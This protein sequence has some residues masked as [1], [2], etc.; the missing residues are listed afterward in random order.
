MPKFDSANPGLRFSPGRSGNPVGRPKSVDK[1]R[2]EVASELVQ[3]GKTLTQMAV[4]RALAGDSACLAACVTL[5][6]TVGVDQKPKV[7]VE[8]TK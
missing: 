2:R 8:P 6:G 7:L 1:L 5:L 4:K 3:H